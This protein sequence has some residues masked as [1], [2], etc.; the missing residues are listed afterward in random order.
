MGDYIYFRIIIE[1]SVRSS[2]LKYDAVLN[3]KVD[4]LEQYKCHRD[5]WCIEWYASQFGGI[6]VKELIAPTLICSDF[7]NVIL[8][9]I[10]N[11]M[12]TQSQL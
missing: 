10:S 11:V 2:T 9:P 3:G 5:S 8:Q 7:Q 1:V 12:P 4:L 6:L